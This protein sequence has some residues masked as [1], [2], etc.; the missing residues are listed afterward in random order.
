MIQTKDVQLLKI[1]DEGGSVEEISRK[2]TEF[3]RSMTNVEDISI[4][5]PDDASDQSQEMEITPLAGSAPPSIDSLVPAPTV[6]GTKMESQGGSSEADSLPDANTTTPSTDSTTAI[7]MDTEQTTS[8]AT[9]SDSNVITDSKV[10]SPS[11]NISNGFLQIFFGIFLANWSK[12]LFYIRRITFAHRR[13]QTISRQLFIR[14]R[15]LGKQ[16]PSSRL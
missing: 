14:W 12:R 4:S 1:I 5:I 16:R 7:P 15:H 13:R 9:P 6:N 10:V 3:V 8:T 11:L 2:L